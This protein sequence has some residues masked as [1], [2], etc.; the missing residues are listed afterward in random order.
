MPSSITAGDYAALAEFRHALRHFINFSAGA[1]RAVGLSSVQHQ[2]MLAIKG[3]G[4]RSGQTVGEIAG[5]LDLRPHSAVGLVDRLVRGGW[6]RRRPDRR[7]RRLVHVTLTLKGERTLA[8][9][10]AA[11]RA[12]V[13]RVGPALRDLLH[14]IG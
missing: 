4:G 10:S 8:H 5:H 6:V 2:A 9:L 1:A 11:H 7:D 3:F 14:R 12:E 13:R